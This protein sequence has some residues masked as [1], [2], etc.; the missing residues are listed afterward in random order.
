MG[1]D[2]PAQALDFLRQDDAELA[3]QPAQTVVEGGAL[4][5]EALPGAVQTE[6]GLLVDVLDW[7]EAHI[8]PGNGFADRCGIRRIILAALAAHPVR[9]HE[10]GRHQFDGMSEL[11]EQSCPVMRTRA[12]LHTD[13]TGR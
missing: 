4:F 10:L 13:Q 5:D 9:R 8:G 3:D 6:D 1:A 2:F 12:G 11:S 7:H